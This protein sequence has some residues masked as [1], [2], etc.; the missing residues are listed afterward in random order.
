MTVLE[1]EVL[2][3]VCEYVIDKDQRAIDDFDLS[4][5]SMVCV[6]Y[7]S[8]VSIFNKPNSVGRCK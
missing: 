4:Y 6:N 8:V 5:L 1:T 2:D 7:G 3:E